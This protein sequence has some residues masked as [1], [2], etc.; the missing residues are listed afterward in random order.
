[1][2]SK[3]LWILVKTGRRGDCRGDMKSPRS[4]WVRV[5]KPSAGGLRKTLGL[6]PLGLRDVDR[7]DRRQAAECLHRLV[8]RPGQAVAGRTDEHVV[9]G[10]LGLEIEVEHVV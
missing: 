8:V 5:V 6:E 4:T 7:G 2:R 9:G 1:M 10:A 3:T